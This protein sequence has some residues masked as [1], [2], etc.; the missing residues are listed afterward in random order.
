MDDSIILYLALGVIAFLYASVGHAGASGYIAVLTLAGMASEVVRPTALILN[1]LVAGLTTFQ[2]VRAGYFAWHRFLPFAVAALPASFLG[3][4]IHVPTEIFKLLIGV[5][6][7]FSA[8][9]FVMKSEDPPA[10]RFP[11]LWVALTV[12]A[13]LGLLSGL[14][15]TGGGIFLTP[16][17]LHLAW[18]RTKET[19]AVSAP[20]I[21]LNSIAGLAGFRVGGGNL[22]ES[23]FVLTLALVVILAGGLGGYF[24]SRR[25]PVKVIRLTLAVVLAI[26]G[27]KLAFGG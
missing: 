5:V 10:T 17:M 18:A 21:L 3:G 12:G 2:F 13:A 8:A 26:A 7:L 11:R 23:G 27:A 25:F 16:L 14:T 4:F 22:P 1:I 15:G 9:R 6:L 20:F 24:G 19:A